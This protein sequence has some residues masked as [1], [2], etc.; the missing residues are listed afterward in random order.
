MHTGVQTVMCQLHEKF[1][2]LSTR[3]AVYI[4]IKKCVICNMYN[5]KPMQVHPAPLLILRVKDAAVFEVIGVD[6]KG[7]VYL[8]GQ[9]KV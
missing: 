4:I 2:I 5:S 8:R 6:F 9:K 1:W 7:S 3:K